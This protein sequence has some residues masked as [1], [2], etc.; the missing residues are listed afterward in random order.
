VS[1][2]ATPKTLR[3]EWECQMWVASAPAMPAAASRGISVEVLSTTGTSPDEVEGETLIFFCVTGFQTDFSASVISTT[4][5]SIPQPPLLRIAL[6]GPQTS[7]QA[8]PRSPPGVIR[9]IPARRDPRDPCP[10]RSMPACWVWGRSTGVRCRAPSPGVG[11]Y[12]SGEALGP[13]QSSCVQRG[14]AVANGTHRLPSQKTTRPSATPRVRPGVGPSTRAHASTNG[15]MCSSGAAS[16]DRSMDSRSFR[17]TAAASGT[18]D[19]SVAPVVAA[20]RSSSPEMSELKPRTA[21]HQSPI[22]ACVAGV[23]QTRDARS[24][25]Q[26]GGGWRGWGE[27]PG[28][29][30]VSGRGG[31][32]SEGERRRWRCSE[33]R[34]G[35]DC[36]GARRDFRTQ[37]RGEISGRRGV[38]QRQ[39]RAPHRVDVYTT[40]L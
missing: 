26:R 3:L 21:F 28:D 39:N 27:D 35:G 25:G 16:A 10:A 33:G 23:L 36:V 11:R 19:L 34:G 22:A 40:I 38:E 5:A 1:C 13:P 31:R 37:G 29:D 32:R 4:S 9:E 15:S 30:A 14:E 18:S 2:S 12:S 8:W 17:S 20:R 6:I 24:R 7:D